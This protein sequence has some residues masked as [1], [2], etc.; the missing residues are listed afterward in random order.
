MSTS[1]RKTPKNP[2]KD[3]Y[4]K[5]GIHAS[6]PYSVWI[7]L[8]GNYAF[9]IEEK[10]VD[11]A[12]RDSIRGTSVVAIKT[13]LGR[14]EELNYKFSSGSEKA[15]FAEQLRTKPL[16]HYHY[17]RGFSLAYD[18][19]HKAWVTE[20][21]SDGLSDSF[22]TLFS[23]V[24][25]FDDEHFELETLHWFGWRHAVWASATDP[26]LLL[27]VSD[28][29]IKPCNEPNHNR[30]IVFI[31]RLRI[32]TRYSL[33]GQAHYIIQSP[34]LL[35]LLR[36][37]ALDIVAKIKR[38][39]EN[40]ETGAVGP[41]TALQ[42][43]QIYF[44]TKEFQQQ[45]IDHEKLVAWDKSQHGAVPLIL[46]NFDSDLLLRMLSRRARELLAE[47][48]MICRQ[49]IFDNLTLLTIGDNKPR[50]R[51]PLEAMEP[52]EG[53]LD[54][55]RTEPWIGSKSFGRGEDGLRKLRTFPLPTKD[56]SKV[57]SLLKSLPPDIEPLVYHRIK[58]QKEY[59]ALIDE[60]DARHVEENGG[61]SPSLLYREL[62]AKRLRMVRTPFHLGGSLS[63]KLEH[64]VTK[65]VERVANQCGT[66]IHR[67]TLE[68]AKRFID[69][70]LA[71]VAITAFSI[72]DLLSLTAWRKTTLLAQEVKTGSLDAS[73]ESAGSTKVPDQPIR[74]DTPLIGLKKR[75]TRTNFNAQAIAKYMLQLMEFSDDEE[76]REM[77]SVLTKLDP[78]L[79]N[80][81][82]SESE[83]L[84][85]QILRKDLKM[86]KVRIRQ[87]IKEWSDRPFTAAEIAAD[88]HRYIKRA[89]S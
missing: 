63:A 21:A 56:I 26:L 24:Q 69:R 10:M 3:L 19:K 9:T 50:L 13:N 16:R 57:K 22:C 89:T 27:T 51:D 23:P 68:M 76:I 53:L 15:A 40:P 36:L 37:E 58:C 34:L 81:N 35:P 84:R 48:A 6:A 66:T 41:L 33:Q 49:C 1:G 67:R 31:R 45:P 28:G 61:P 65:A 82:R 77:I 47:E 39:F 2:C 46:K 14:I 29:R 44:E 17:D 87:T 25:V 54:Y 59:Q 70:G 86:L 52:G 79:V 60:A 5:G 7:G 83:R 11:I 43:R 71:P 4:L 85:Y 80:S 38:F 30:G 78:L 18:E 88:D 74:Q 64:K 42:F 55:L 32:E 12:I 73:G 20:V 75:V 8:R 62:E 72:D